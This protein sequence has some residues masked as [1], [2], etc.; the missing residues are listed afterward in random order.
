MSLP[1]L[2]STPSYAGRLH[3]ATLVQYRHPWIR[4]D[5]SLIHV[6][7]RDRILLIPDS[8]TKRNLHLLTLWGAR[9][10]ERLCT[11]SKGVARVY[12]LATGEVVYEIDNGSKWFALPD[13][14]ALVHTPKYALII[15]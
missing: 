10:E 9:N 4:C 2:H 14:D 8:V 12:N 11:L 15:P 13:L 5:D 3:N 1:P 6:A 7:R